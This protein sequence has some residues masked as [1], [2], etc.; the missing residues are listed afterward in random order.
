MCDCCLFRSVGRTQMNEQS[1][2]S[3]CL[4]TLRISGINKVSVVNSCI[5]EYLLSL[6]MSL[7]SKTISLSSCD[8]F[9]QMSAIWCIDFHILTFILYNTSLKKNEIIEM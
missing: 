2:R 9:K 3:H 1:S 4:F 8:G 6:L 5:V 7:T